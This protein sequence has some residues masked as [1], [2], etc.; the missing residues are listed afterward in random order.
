SQKSFFPLAKQLEMLEPTGDTHLSAA[1]RKIAFARFPRGIYFLL[2]DFYSYDGFE[3]LKLLAASGNEIHCLQILT[4][5]EVEPDLRGDLKLR[6]SETSD[7][8]EVSISPQILKK[9]LARLNGLQQELKTTAHQSFASCNVLRT[10]TP[11]STLILHELR[12][13]GVVV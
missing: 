1:L 4:D 2:S 10:S 7:I 11:L 6:D 13:F 3:G 9:Y 12:S 8:A 5:E